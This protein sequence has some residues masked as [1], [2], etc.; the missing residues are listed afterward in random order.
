MEYFTLDEYP[1]LKFPWFKRP[2]EYLWKIL[3][4][5]V[6]SRDNGLCRYCGDRV[7]LFECHIH[8]TLELTEGGSNHPT[9]LKTSCVKCHKI[10][11]PFMRS[12]RDK[13]YEI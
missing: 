4:Q 6:Y 7:E 10:K 5:Y 12:A 2:P 11:H 3:R 9:N 8:H 13:L 1:K